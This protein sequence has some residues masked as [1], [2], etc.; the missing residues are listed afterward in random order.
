[1]KDSIV[2]HYRA[3]AQEGGRTRG[4]AVDDNT[5]S[6]MSSDQKS[7]PVVKEGIKSE[8]SPSRRH[9]SSGDDFG[10]DPAPTG[11]I[12][13]NHDLKPLPYPQSTQEYLEHLLS[14]DCILNACLD[15]QVCET[16]PGNG[17][18]CRLAQDCFNPHQQS[19]SYRRAPGYWAVEL[20]KGEIT[21]RTG[22][23]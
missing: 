22:N 16:L 21:E 15:S 18:T 7:L 3:I 4:R 10:S 19:K 1:M 13:S 23:A 11:S 8:P 20:E 14:I 17:V 12:D 2:S 9:W 5:G 6:T